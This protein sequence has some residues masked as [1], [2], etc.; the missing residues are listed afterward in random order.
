[1]YKKVSNL[2]IELDLS[3]GTLSLTFKNDFRNDLRLEER[4]QLYVVGKYRLI[5][6]LLLLEIKFSER[7]YNRNPIM[8]KLTLDCTFI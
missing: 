6:D 7:K 5:D 4:S 2:I 8:R 3:S 1:M